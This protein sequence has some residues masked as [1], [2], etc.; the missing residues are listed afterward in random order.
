M[1]YRGNLEELQAAEVGRCI[2]GAVAYVANSPLSYTDPSGKGF[3]S[4]FLGFLG[5]I[6][7]GWPLGGGGGLHNVSVFMGCGGP[8]GNLRFRTRKRALERTVAGR[9]RRSGPGKV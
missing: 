6:L 9:N 8:L 4:D 2:S 1:R 3:S 5:D 7:G